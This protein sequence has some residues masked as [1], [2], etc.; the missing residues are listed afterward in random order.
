MLRSKP[1][2]GFTLIELLVVIAIIAVLIGLLLPAVQ[3]VREAANRMACSNNLKQLG[4]AA[5]NYEST[6]GKLPPGYLG[7]KPN[8]HYD[9]GTGP[10]QYK[11]TNASH[12]GV[13]RYLLPYLEQSA[14]D[15]E[16][17]RT[18]D[19][20]FIF[21]PF[22]PAADPEWYNYNPDY[23]LAHT[24]IKSFRC[25][26]MANVQPNQ[27]MGTI[28][29]TWEPIPPFSEKD[30]PTGNFG[31]GAVF[32]YFSFASTPDARTLG[33]TNYL[34]VAGVLGKNA[35]NAHPLFLNPDKS[36][37]NF[38]KYDG[39]FGNRSQTK[40]AD[41]TDGTSNT[42]MFGECIGGKTYPTLDFQMAWIGCGALGTR[43]GLGKAGIQYEQGGSNWVRFSSYHPGGVQ[44]CLADGSVRMVAFGNTAVQMV[45][46][47]PSPIVPPN[48]WFVLQ[49]MA[50]MH[51]STVV[52]TSSIAP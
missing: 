30:P 49:S 41:I 6:Y 13:L 3:K 20:N 22:P 10:N 32:F 2:S 27:G 50:G 39:I 9:D 11:V 18:T 26:S 38:Q 44:F 4:L 48:D 36:L 43:L 1:R 12:V 8:I 29:H 52:D 31:G 24:S 19:V 40:I 7:P 17:T 45:Y 28:L 15:V 51:D 42:L 25:P 37:I 16:L 35:T 33:T 46:D 34:G 14:I 21:P 23:T 5:M 47:P